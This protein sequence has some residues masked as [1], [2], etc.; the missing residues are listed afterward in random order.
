MALD[1]KD[2]H[3]AKRLLLGSKF[4]DP[5]K[6]DPIFLPGFE[7]LEGYELEMAGHAADSIGFALNAMG[8]KKIGELPQYVH[9]KST[10][11]YNK[12]NRFEKTHGPIRNYKGPNPVQTKKG[13]KGTSDAQNI[14]L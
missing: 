1:Y 2:R 13:G 11:T 5:K 12:E 10:E 14:D 7:I 8:Y 9:P 3:D 4:S 6:R